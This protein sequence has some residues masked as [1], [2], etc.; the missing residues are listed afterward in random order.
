[1]FL[2]GMKS[3]PGTVWGASIFFSASVFSVS[4]F[5]KF[6]FSAS[7]YAVLVLSVSIFFAVG[8]SGQAI[9]NGGS[10]SG[11]NGSASQFCSDDET[12][13]LNPFHLVEPY[14]QVGVASK[15]ESATK[16]EFE[17]KIEPETAPYGD[18]SVSGAFQNV[19]KSETCAFSLEE[20]QGE[21]TCER[22]TG[23]T[24]VG[25]V[26]EW[27]AGSGFLEAD[28]GSSQWGNSVSGESVALESLSGG[29]SSNTTFSESYSS[30]EMERSLPNDLLREPP[31]S[32][33]S[34][35]QKATFEQSLSGG[36]GGSD[37][38]GV[39]HTDVSAMFALPGPGNGGVFLFSPLAAFDH[40][41][42]TPNIPVSDDLY[43][44]G[45]NV[46]WMKEV[47]EFWRV[48]LFA[49]PTYS[50]DF[51]NT[52]GKALRTPAGGVGIWTPTPHW[53]FLFGVVYTGIED[54]SVLPLCGAIWQ[55]NE[56]WKIEMTLPKPRLCHRVEWNSSWLKSFWVYLA[57]EYAGSS[58]A[59]D[60]GGRND[61]M[62]CHELRLMLGVERDRPKIGE[63]DFSV[64]IGFSFCRKLYFEDSPLEYEPDIG[65]VEKIEI[66]F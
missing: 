9:A 58:W 51:Q 42:E 41:Y 63:I 47:N 18:H 64:E 52:S 50:S 15:V 55:P 39:F 5:S 10:F 38:F 20:R 8:A 59:V 30:G 4:N 44:V 23:E 6:V 36:G 43:R 32:R 2:P 35:F 17:T 25:A 62:S 11:G 26:G 48:M 33:N 28:S 37:A 65:F 53:Q 34:F 12:F 14:P 56:D 13:G 29:I 16:V 66:K 45:L 60:F 49:S 61:L 3:L 1:M 57:G 40:F 31:R 21:Q 54:W 22:Q 19:A 7:I 27:E 46:T 24:T